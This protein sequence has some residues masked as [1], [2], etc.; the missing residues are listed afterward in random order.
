MAGRDPNGISRRCSSVRA[1]IGGAVCGRDIVHHDPSS[2]KH[3]NTSR[4][5]CIFHVARLFSS[6]TGVPSGLTSQQP[7]VFVHPH[8]PRLAIRHSALR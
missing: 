8:T 2:N 5:I 6:T 3:S 4:Y 1:R 7:L